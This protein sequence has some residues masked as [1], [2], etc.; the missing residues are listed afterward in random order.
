MLFQPTLANV[1]LRRLPGDPEL[2]TSRIITPE[3]ADKLN[4][5]SAEVLAVGPG[6]YG[7]KSGTLT[8]T[9]LAVGDH[10]LVLFGQWRVGSELDD[11]GDERVISAR[12][13]QAV[14]ER[15]P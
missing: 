8:P 13:V 1:H 7:E 5:V 14:I 12:G 15:G 11:K 9:G 4:Y 6:W 3:T 2:K 10:V